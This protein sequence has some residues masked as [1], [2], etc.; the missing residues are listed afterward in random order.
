MFNR[1]EKKIK[2]EENKLTSERNARCI[3]IANKILK[4]I[5]ECEIKDK[6]QYELSKD[7]NQIIVDIIQILLDEGAKAH[8][9]NYILQLV[10]L[11]VDVVKE[12]V[13]KTLNKHLSTAADNLWIKESGRK[14]EEILVIDIDRTLK[15][16]AIVK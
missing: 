11:P 14:Y 5:V 15:T 16:E 3:P 12:T 10:L 13:S 9:V 7:Y 1:V 8:E 6:P 4:K 2:K